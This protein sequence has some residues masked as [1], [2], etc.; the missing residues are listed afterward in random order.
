MFLR[1]QIGQHG[2]RKHYQIAV[3]VCF[4]KGSLASVVS[5]PSHGLLQLGWKMKPRN[6]HVENLE[7]EESSL[8]VCS[9]D[10]SFDQ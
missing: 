4:P 10:S 5:F 3:V 8:S 9:V 6:D 7:E 1:K 2:T